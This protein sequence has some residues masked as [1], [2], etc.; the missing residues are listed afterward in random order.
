MNE[1]NRIVGHDWAVDILRAAIRHE[2][3]GHAYLITGPAQVGKTTLARTFAQALNC[4]AADVAARPCGKCRPCQL[5]AADR[6]TDVR[7]L[8]PEVGSRGNP[9]IKIDQIRTLQQ[10][11]SLAAYEARW[12]VAILRQF[13][14]ANASAANAF[15]KT[16][17]EPPRQV[18][19]LMTATDA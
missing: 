3:V 17:E 1:W 9:I 10:E 18:V 2:R 6:H 8:Q 11:L 7:L 12:K 14:A 4:Q 5:I 15:L 19:L 13:E 16:L